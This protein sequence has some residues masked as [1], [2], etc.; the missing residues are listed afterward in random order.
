MSAQ[1][2]GL[3]A[4]ERNRVKAT[5]IA[6]N[7]DSLSYHYDLGST[8]RRHREVH[9]I[10]VPTRPLKRDAPVNGCTHEGRDQF[11]HAVI[12]GAD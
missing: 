8:G 4:A 5:K 10:P 6:L 3:G 2:I 1:D 9:V 12:Q 7:S 11:W